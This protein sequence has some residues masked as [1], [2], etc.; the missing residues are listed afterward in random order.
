MFYPSCIKPI[1]VKGEYYPCGKCLLCRSKLRN[2]WV[3][4]CEFE[5]CDHSKSCFLT[6]TFTEENVAKY[7]QNE[8]LNV[9]YDDVRYFFKRVRKN[10][11]KFRYF[12]VFELGKKAIIRTFIL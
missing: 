11:G 2:E 8:D 1:Y 10:Y 12:G 9:L 7:W 4:R 6:L 5:L 3:Q